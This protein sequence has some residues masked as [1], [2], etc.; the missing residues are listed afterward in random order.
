MLLFLE[1]IHLLVV[2]TNR[3]Y[4]QYLDTLDKGQSVLP[5]MTVQEMCSFLAIILQMG[6]DLKDTLKAYW[7]TVEQFI[8][9]LYG[10][11]K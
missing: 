6:H 1:I 8:T 5:D 9:P 3:Y 11:M 7:S 4:H 2:E 10:K